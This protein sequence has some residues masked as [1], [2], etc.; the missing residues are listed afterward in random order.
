MKK[1]ISI[2]WGLFSL[3]LFSIFSQTS[4]SQT[5]NDSPQ[6]KYIREYSEIAVKEMLR[7]GVP[8]SITL[9]QGLLESNSGRSLLATKGNNHFGIK[10]HEWKGPS[11]N[12]DDD[13]KGECFRKYKNPAHS[14][15]DHSDFLRYRDRYKFLFDFQ[16]TDYK[17]WS[18]GLKKAGYAT[19]PAYATKLIKL[20]ETYELYRFDDKST[21]YAHSGKSILPAPPHKL[22]EAQV[23]EPNSREV[24]KL[25]LSTKLYSQNGVTFIYSIEGDSY[26]SI[27]KKYNLFN[28]ELL[29]FNDLS[30][31]KPLYPGTVVYLERKRIRTVKNIEKH[32]A[33]GEESLRDIAQRYGVRLKSLSRV[34]GL[35]KTI[36]Q[37][38]DGAFIPRENYTIKLR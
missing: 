21:N 36:W 22:E 9:A 16:P 14:F 25:S 26:E 15:E 23:L 24:F 12:F 31:S 7:S 1:T 3:C 29:S 11:M 30:K 17:A 33:N 38:D 8:A 2:I 6:I 28:R 35:S 18:Y 19:D 10:C 13:K 37:K 20:I 4:N 5:S 34:N 32:I 27:A